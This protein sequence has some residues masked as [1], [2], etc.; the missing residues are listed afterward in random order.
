MLRPNFLNTIT[1][2]ASSPKQ[3]DSM[4]HDT[5]RIIFHKLADNTDACAFK[6]DFLKYCQLLLHGSQISLLYYYIYNRK[7]NW[8]SYYPSYL[9]RY[10][11]SDECEA[12]TNETHQL[13][14]RQVCFNSVSDSFDR[15]SIFQIKL[16]KQTHS[17][18]LTLDLTFLLFKV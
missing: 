12:L 4:R 11:P 8:L 16:M 7:G 17:V 10:V 6:T 1:S 2:N 14:N 9:T 13:I 15:Y 18:P 5:V 3:S